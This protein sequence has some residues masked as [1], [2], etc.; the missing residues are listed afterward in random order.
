MYAVRACVPFLKLLHHLP[1]PSHPNLQYLV[2]IC[3]VILWIQRRGN[4]DSPD[5]PEI[6]H[7]TNLIQAQIRSDLV[8]YG[9][10]QALDSYAI[11][12]RLARIT[13]D[14]TPM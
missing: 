3:L 8:D 7:T 11:A 12:D 10:F 14:Y 4:A 1:I 5:A 6:E 2:F 9:D 13:D